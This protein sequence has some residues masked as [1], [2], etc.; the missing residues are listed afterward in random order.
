M[1]DQ[2]LS[3][4]LTYAAK[5][6]DYLICIQNRN[7][8]LLSNAVLV[9]ATGQAFPANPNRVALTVGIDLTIFPTTAFYSILILGGVFRH[10]LFSKEADVAASTP[11]P[12][13]YHPFH[14]DITTLGPLLCGAITLNISA[15]GTPTYC[16]ETV[17]AAPSPA[18]SER[19]LTSNLRDVNL[20]PVGLGKAPVKQ[21][22]GR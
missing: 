12:L 2:V 8:L 11:S 21:M 5:L 9:N 19:A 10:T 20:G 1:N 22:R 18:P 3:E 16:V 17:L 15:G 6:T 7:R 4:R 14:A 13:A